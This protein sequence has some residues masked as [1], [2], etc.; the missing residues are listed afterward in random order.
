MKPTRNIHRLPAIDSWQRQPRIRNAALH[1]IQNITSELHSV[2]EE[3]HA[4]LTATAGA[5]LPKLFEDINAVKLLNDFKAE[6][7][8]LRRVLWFYI[9]QASA[10]ATAVTDHT[11]Q[12]DRMQRVDELL[13]TL[14]PQPST[15][16]VGEGENKPSVSFFERLDVV[17]DTY[18]QEKKP[19]MEAKAAKAGH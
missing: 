15:A 19:V 7:D 17:I 14:V 12:A 9:E 3:M 13:R 6:L 1:R 16:A 4:E 10:H 11:Q 2:Q 18:M 5:R 8:Q